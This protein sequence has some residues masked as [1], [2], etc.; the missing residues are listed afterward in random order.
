MKMY[1]K[2]TGEAKNITL[3]IWDNKRDDWGF[4]GDWFAEIAYD[5]PNDYPVG[6]ID[7]DADCAVT[8][9]E[10][11]EIV[12][13]WAS[14]VSDYNNRTRNNYFVEGLDDDDIDKE[15]EKGLEYI[16]DAD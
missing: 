5:L 16:F 15:Y 12:D 8:E 4:P 7:T 2:E 6:D 14:E 10:Y 11:K 9:Q 3:R 1:I 13:W